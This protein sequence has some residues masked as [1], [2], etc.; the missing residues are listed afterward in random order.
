[1]N[2]SPKST[3]HR[4]MFFSHNKLASAS[5]SSEKKNNQLNRGSRQASKIE[6]VR[7]LC[8]CQNNGS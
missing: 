6:H 8:I 7:Q 1:M 3:S 2:G 5:A 4:T